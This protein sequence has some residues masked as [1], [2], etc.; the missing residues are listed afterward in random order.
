MDAINNLR[1]IFFN[2]HS[3]L[4]VLPAM[5]EYG[6]KNTLVLS[7]SSTLIAIVLGIVLAVMGMSHARPVRWLARIYTDLFR[8]LPA[9][10]TI[11]LIGQGFAPLVNPL[12]GGNPYPLGIAALSLIYTAYLGEIF[13]GG[14]LAIDSGQA[15]AARALGMTG[16]AA[17]RLI[18]LPQSIRSVLPSVM[19][20]FIAVVKDSS[21]VF[22]LGLIL[23]QR[24]LFRVAQD[25]SVV[26][27]NLSPLVLAG[28]FYLII[29]VPLTHLVNYVD[30]RLRKGPRPDG[31]S[32]RDDLDPADANPSV[33]TLEGAIGSRAA[34]GHN[35]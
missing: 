29:T 13:R 3:M 32:T 10:L 23:N 1:S 33:P 35:A 15:E 24:E 5:L 22:F 12:T 16:S 14:I 31:Q 25:A 20:Q 6:L 27:G 4:A 9:I 7:I 28:A 19:N 30:N 18:V 11:L 26:E 2:L 21:L 8:G 17:T 34:G